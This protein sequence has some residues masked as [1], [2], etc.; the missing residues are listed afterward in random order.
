MAK[1]TARHAGVPFLFVSATSFQSM[2]YGMTARK[3]RA[4]LKALRKAARQ[5][6]GGAIGF[7]EEIDAIGARRGDLDGGGDGPVSSGT[8]GVVNELLV[9]LQSFDPRRW[10]SWPTSPSAT[11]GDGRAPAG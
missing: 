6:E 2:W 11:P 5:Q 7:L 10:G 4:F 3:I 1:A 9:Q 8:G